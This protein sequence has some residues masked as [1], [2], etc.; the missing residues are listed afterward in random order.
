MVLLLTSLFTVAWAAL[1]FFLGCLLWLAVRWRAKRGA[2]RLSL[3]HPV[4]LLYTWPLVVLRSSTWARPIEQS[5]ARAARAA[6]VLAMA[7]LGVLAV[8]GALVLLSQA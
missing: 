3:G 2:E 6:G 1:V 5:V 7:S 8:V 4:A